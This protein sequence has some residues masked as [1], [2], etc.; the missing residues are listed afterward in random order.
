M[1]V[2]LQQRQQGYAPAKTG[3]LMQMIQ[4]VGEGMGIRQR[5]FDLARKIVN[6]HPALAQPPWTGC[7]RVRKSLQGAVLTKERRWRGGCMLLTQYQPLLAVGNNAAPAAQP[8]MVRA[9]D[10][11]GV[12]KEA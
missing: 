1:P 12:R 8:G 2:A 7:K 3:L 11:R 6:G 10:E 9:G 4:Q 5:G